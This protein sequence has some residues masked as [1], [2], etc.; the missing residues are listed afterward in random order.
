MMINTL[1]VASGGILGALARYMVSSLFA[2]R[3]PVMFPWG[4][5]SINLTGSFLLGFI[6][7]APR[8]ADLVLFMGTGFLGAF[9]TFSTF[10]L[11][12][13][14]LIKRGKIKMAAAYLAFSYTVGILAALL[15]YWLAK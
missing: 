1:L 6:L 12:N 9:T 7:A 10:K 11:E 2:R 14:Q 8:H 5:L 13:V 4:T 3:G 15:G